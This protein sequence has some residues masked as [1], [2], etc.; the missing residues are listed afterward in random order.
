MFDKYLLGTDYLPGT[1]PGS[2]NVTLRQAGTV[3]V[4][5]SPGKAGMKQMLTRM[6]KYTQRCGQQGEARGAGRVSG[7]WGA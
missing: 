4:P 7:S 3:P 2:G 6:A 1:V 5:P